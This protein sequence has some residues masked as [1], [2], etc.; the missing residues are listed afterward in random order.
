[1]V[2]GMGIENQLNWLEHCRERPFQ[3]QI[4]GTS[5]LVKL[6]TAMLADEMGLGKTKE[7]I[8]AAQVL[9]HLG[10]VD[11]VLVVCPAGVRGVW[12]DQEL[13]ELAKHLWLD[14]AGRV[15]EWHAKTRGWT[16]GKEGAPRLQWL[17]VNYEFI[18]R[19]NRLAQVLPFC[20]QKT[21]LVLDESSAVKNH[22]A[23]Q[24]KACLQLRRRCG[25]VV[26]LN[27]TPIAH[28]PIDMYSQGNIMDPK[29]LGCASYFHFRSK[30]AIMGGWQQKQIIGWQNL[31]DLQQRFAPY[32]LRRLKTDCLDLPSKLPSQMI[33]ATLTP[34]TWNIYKEMRDE[35]VA[36]LDQST[37]A[38]ASQA[39]IKT[40]RLAQITSGFVG[41]IQD[42]Q[43][44]ELQ[45]EDEA[46]PSWVPPGAP[47]SQT[48]N[49]R[50]TFQGSSN[51]G[52]GVNI[53]PEQG[54]VE[55]REVGR[56]KLD[57]FLEWLDDQ[58][59][60]D[61]HLK[62]LV[63][64][65]FRAE[66]HRLWK[67]LAGNTKY[68]KLELGLIWG[69]QK[70][71]EREAAIRLLDPRTMPTGPVVVLG[72]PASGSMGLNLA[73]AH[74]VIYVS[75]DYS[76]KT[77]LQSEDRVHRPGQTYPVSYF[78][79]IAVGPQGQKTID[80]AVIKALRTREDLATWTTSAWIQALKD[81]SKEEV[82][83]F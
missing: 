44:F 81:E 50:S 63:W 13:G 64:C 36:W 53:L 57:T 12:F 34:E 21:L 58:L 61:P 83:V 46:R 5:F 30:Y 37:V 39:F 29:I 62:V 14:Q 79:I 7:T 80:H 41:G 11:R 67:T 23:E 32:V 33:T 55:V 69:G 51:P 9:Y 19:K 73:G 8:D 77:R 43:E 17:I 76:L 18:R 42:E 71:E 59:N 28:S 40:L 24:T 56:E 38:T 60:V 68:L 26:L 74:T 54:T 25:R 72:T 16:Y 82:A 1:M 6:T 20:G 3:H 10:L 48:P 49:L 31:E 66:L 27:G 2:L 78:D 75:N 52:Q 65:R 45:P 22:R 15:I 4:I 35:L 70:R 47:R